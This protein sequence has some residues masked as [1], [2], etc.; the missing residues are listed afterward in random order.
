M[1]NVMGDCSKKKKK[2]SYKIFIH[3]KSLKGDL[4]F[5]FFLYVLLGIRNHFPVSD[6]CVK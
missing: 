3:L 5:F 4:F 6:L 2:V 1:V